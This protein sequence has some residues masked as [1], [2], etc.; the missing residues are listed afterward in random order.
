MQ[1]LQA[2]ASGI[3][4]EFAAGVVAAGPLSRIR[5]NTW[6]QFILRR[7]L[8][9]AVVLAVLVFCDFLILRLIPGDPAEILAG[10]TGAQDQVPIIRHEL[11]LDLPLYGQMLNY[12][13]NLLHGDLGHSFLTNQ[14]VTEIISQRIGSS[15]TLAGSALVLVLVLGISIG[16]ILG[17]L[18]REDRHRRLELAFTATTS[19]L[20]S[21]PEYFVA[22]LLAFIFGL[23][24]RLLPIAGTS[25]LAGLILPTAA[26][27]IRPIAILARVVRVEALN[28]LAQDYVRTARSKRLPARLIY[29]R[30]VL[31]NVV[32]AALTISGIL[33]A[34]LVGGAIVIE[35]VF[36][37]N[38]LG[39]TLVTAVLNRDYPV[40][41]GVILILGVIVVLVNAIIDVVIALIDPRSR[42]RLA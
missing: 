4:D 24:L 14:A 23:E 40:I 3:R 20:G 11:G 7:L 26:I 6:T 17:A 29:L 32:T 37:R 9:L 5:G 13:N 15:V 30:H 28:V 19:V 42:A 16:M 33:F 41:Q 39:T 35:N 21:L 18:T 2:S 8:N 12:A 10:V 36:D 31:P 25:D 22:T 1:E 34:Q 38:G 27:A